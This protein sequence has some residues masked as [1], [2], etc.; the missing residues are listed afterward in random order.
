VPARR[1]AVEYR[2]RPAT[3]TMNT[4]P[5]NGYTAI[6][7]KELGQNGVKNPIVIW[8]N[9][10]AMSPPLYATLL[11]HLAS[12]GFAILAYD[13]TPQ[14]AQM[15]A[16]ID[17]MIAENARQ[18]SPYE[19]KLDTTKIAAMGH[20]AGSIATFQIASD[21]R[22]TT[23]MHLDGG[24]FDPHTDIKN[25]KAP[26][27]FICGDSGGDGLLVGDVARPNCD[28][29]FMNATTPVWYG[30]VKGAGHLTISTGAATDPMM[31]K[32]FL[33]A[34]AGW[35]RWQLMGDQTMKKLFVGS[36]CDLCSNTAV[37]T[38]QQKNLM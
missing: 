25:L 29:D 13:T 6:V 28:I 4:G 3:T 20:S 37:W 7:A 19:G 27:A 38:V 16:A 22:L 10:A 12:H 18:G 5:M 11:N 31:A 30:D 8:G 9:G 14:G 17:W 1:A 34:T 24:T 15:T 36:T 33:A 2:R 23:T 21:M 26:A 32:G 35:L